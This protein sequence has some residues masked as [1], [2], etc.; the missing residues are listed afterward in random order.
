MD[1]RSTSILICLSALLLAY[2]SRIIN[3][4]QYDF[5]YDEI[6][7][8]LVGRS[9]S[10]ADAISATSKSVGSTPLDYMVTW[11]VIHVAGET[12]FVVRYMALVWNVITIALVYLTGNLVNRGSGKWAA[13]I[14][15]ISPLAIRYSQEARFYSLGLM[16]GSAVIAVAALA[17]QSRIKASWCTWCIVTVLA[18]ASLYTFVYAI[19][20]GCAGMLIII[21]CSKRQFRMRLMIWFGTAIAAAGILFLPWFFGGFNATPQ[22]PGVSSIGSAELGWILAGLELTKTHPG[23]APSIGSETYPLII[24]VLSVAS[25]IYAILLTLCQ[26]LT[27]HQPRLRR[28]GLWLSI[29]LLYVASAAFVSI[30]TVRVHYFFHPRQYLF[31]LT[32][33]ALLFGAVLWWIEK[34]IMTLQGLGMMRSVKVTIMILAILCLISSAGSYTTMRVNR[35]ESGSSSS[36]AR[37]L[38]EQ[39]DSASTRAWFVPKWMSLS[40]DYY[41][42]RFALN[43]AREQQTEPPVPFKWLKIPGD[44]LVAESYSMLK[45]A[46][47]GSVIVVTDG[48]TITADKMKNAGFVRASPPI[49][50]HTDFIVYRKELQP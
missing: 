46:P 24:R 33:R 23:F 35:L 19:L 44:L 32:E 27:L 2:I 8:V 21:F 42:E 45:S 12:E 29:I 40:V 39:V 50:E 28:N 17:A 5:W 34:R 37:Y 30:N 48:S 43:H 14:I 6:G 36:V 22:P 41:I 20:L 11:A 49:N 38:A 31:L 26:P 3:L 25:V 15:V 4:G 13:L 16:L 18:A 10:L 1:G 7:S 47:P 9:P